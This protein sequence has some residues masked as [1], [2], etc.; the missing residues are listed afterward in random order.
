MGLVV[1]KLHFGEDVAAQVFYMQKLCC[2]LGITLMAQIFFGH[3]LPLVVG[4]ASVLLIGILASAA[5]DISAIYTGILIGGVFIT[6]IAVSGLL[7]HFRK[8]FTPRVISVIMLLIPVTLA[9][10]I[11]KLGFAN[12]RNT[13]FN[14]AFILLIPLIL[15]FVNKILKGA[16]KS[17]TLIWGIL[18]GSLLVY[19]YDGLPDTGMIS[20]NSSPDSLFIGFQFD[21]GVTLSFLFCSVALIINEVSSIQAVGQMLHAPDMKKR[22]KWGVAITGLSNILSGSMGVIG[23]IDYSS[24]VGIISSTRGASRFPFVPTAILLIICSFFPDL[25]KMLLS[26]PDLVMGTVM[27]YVMVSQFSAGMQMITTNHAVR[28]FEDGAIIGLPVM[29]ALLISFIPGEVMMEIPA[30]IRPICGNGFVMGVIIVLL[31]E[32]LLSD[33]RDTKALKP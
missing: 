27:L 33:K 24:S 2:I 3:R 5:S 12:D 17:T 31:M 4:P 26:I 25:V 29:A 7:T 15:V 18:A 21:W 23:S 8:I 19:W 13:A 30:L 6:V 16:W 9:P 20:T 14:L 1:A 10:T 22:N 28:H 11:L 32:H